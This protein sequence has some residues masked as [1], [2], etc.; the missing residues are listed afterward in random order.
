MLSQK[1]FTKEE[2]RENQAEKA[3]FSLLELNKENNRIFEIDS[4]IAL[5]SHILKPEDSIQIGSVVSNQES[6]NVFLVNS[7][8]D[9]IDNF[10][11]IYSGFIKTLPKFIGNKSKEISLSFINVLSSESKDKK[12]DISMVRDLNKVNIFIP[13]DANEA[14]YLIRVSEKK[15]FKNVQNGF[16]YFRL[17]NADSPKIFEDNY[18][19]EYDNL[20]EYT[21]MPE[22]VF[23]SKNNESAF[24]VGIITTGPVLYN[25][26]VAAREL[27]ERNYDVTILNVSLISSNS[28]YI[29]QKIKSFILNFA[30]TNK[31][32][33]TVEEHSK[34]G[35]LGSLVAETVTESR[36]NQIIRV[37]RLG[38]EEDLSPR[39]II[40]KC[41]EI[42]G[43]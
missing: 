21:G 41:E 15:I 38:L 20:R 17:S 43:W 36:N 28:E 10:L 39:N 6:K 29:N 31:N 7:I 27:E 23:I 25:A 14:E 37:E 11:K 2:E 16:S 30:N 26:L 40:S 32:I 19:I 8:K 33:L 12:S 42:C 34:N 5:Q 24:K 4:D 9:S 1:L 13:A 18:F 22:V 3:L 35:G